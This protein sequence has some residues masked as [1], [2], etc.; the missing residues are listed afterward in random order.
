MPLLQ[1]I[2]KLITDREY[3]IK[4]AF[5]IAIGTILILLWYSRVWPDPWNSILIDGTVTF[6]AVT[7]IQILWDFLGG[8][9][10]E[11]KLQN[12][13][14]SISLIADIGQSNIG[15]E[16]VWVSRRQWHIDTRDGFDAWQKR[17]ASAAQ[18]DIQSNTFWN[19]WFQTVSLREDLRKRVELHQL[20]FRLLIY[21]PRSPI[22]VLRFYDEPE[23]SEAKNEKVDL[24]EHVSA[25]YFEILHTINEFWHIR[26]NLPPEVRQNWQMRLSH[27]YL[28]MAQIIRCDNKIL[29]SHYL[30]DET[31][32]PSPTSQLVYPSAYFQTYQEQ[33]KTNW[34]RAFVLEEVY[35]HIQN[36]VPYSTV[37]E[38]LGK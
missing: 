15:I 38:E 30:N 27:R 20:K 32:A 3:R 11:D 28:H 16:R 12:I 17:M 6:W 19:N 24:H 26:E 1:R 8:D 5:F 13:E 10:L 37:L 23:K 7:I 36:N 29:L 25:M 22:Q 2:W 9:P 31:G 4:L 18:L 35:E 14:N 21:Y 34:K 33:F